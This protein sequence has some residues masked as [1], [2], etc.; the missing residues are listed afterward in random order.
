MPWTL[1]MTLLLTLI[2][3]VILLYLGLRLHWA[4]R[5]T[6]P[7]GTRLFT[8][9]FLAAVTLFLL[10][11][12]TA[13]VQNAMGYG[14]S[15]ETVPALLVYPFWVGLI[16]SGVLL[17]WF[18]TIDILALIGKWSFK[19]DLVR[20]N[21]IQ[22]RLMLFLAAATALYVT[23]KTAW[24]THHIGLDEIAYPLDEPGLDGF[25]IVHISDLQAD[26]YTTVRKMNRYVDMINQ[27]GPDLVI[28]AGDLVTEGTGY[29]MA[30]ARALAG[31]ES[32]HGIYAVIGDHDY[33]AGEEQVVDELEQRGIVVLRNENHWIEHQQ[34]VVKLT[35]VTEIYNQKID[36]GRLQ[37][38]TDEHRGEGLS[39]MVA[40]QATDK[41]MR[42]ALEAGYHQLLAGHT[43]GG[44]IKVPVFFYQVSGARRDT[45]YVQGLWW[46]DNTLFNIS[47]GLG[48]TL[49]P[50]RYNA[51]A[52]ISVITIE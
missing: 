48:F 34:N 39:I 7:G 2:M 51:P 37:Q 17:S 36:P 26:R 47:S 38:L 4:V 6:H 28:F 16:F 21:T 24:D 30:G 50:V 18:I 23:G 29:V 46:F 49:A 40:H 1:R 8:G 12:A 44:Q 41:I 22:A 20:F 19:T 13:Y 14:F 42:E 52:R 25:T 45:P 32:E 5:R 27:A 10:Y 9:V 43:H 11:P 3:S 15:W 31:I 35:G 33:W